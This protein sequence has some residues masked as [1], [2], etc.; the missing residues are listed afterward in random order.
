[1]PDTDK[2]ETIEDVGGEFGFRLRWRVSD[3]WA[4]VEAWEVAAIC[5]GKKEFRSSSDPFR[6]FTAD[7]EKAEKYLDGFIKWDGCAELNQGCPHWCGAKDFKKHMALLKY[8]YLRSS[9]L[10][11]RG[12]DG[13]DTPWNSPKQDATPDLA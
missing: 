12:E 10:M 6:E 11:G 9:V 5:E 1:M 2:R 4:D 8:I 7:V 13:L 3:H